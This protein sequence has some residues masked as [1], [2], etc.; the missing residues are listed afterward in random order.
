MKTSAP[1][2]TKSFAA[3]KPIPVVPPV[4][5]ATF[6]CNLPIVVTPVS[7]REAGNIC[8][9]V[10]SQSRALCRD[11]DFDLVP[12]DPIG[13]VIFDFDDHHRTAAIDQLGSRPAL[14]LEDASY[15]RDV[16]T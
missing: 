2:L 13:A 9:S 15:G 16:L 11:S 6:P 4:M 10:L 3:A 12:L 7:D 8:T 1:S 14:E 5:T